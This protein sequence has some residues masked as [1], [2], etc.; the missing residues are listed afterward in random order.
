MN[1][2]TKVIYNF[3]YDE[4]GLTEIS[5]ELFFSTIMTEAFDQFHTIQFIEGG[6]LPSSGTIVQPLITDY[7][8]GTP[9]YQKLYPIRAG[10][11]QSN[12]TRSQIIMSPYPINPSAYQ[13]EYGEISFGWWPI[14]NTGI[15]EVQPKLTGQIKTVLF[16]QN[17]FSSCVLRLN[18]FGTNLVNCT[19]L[20]TE[21]KSV[22]NFGQMPITHVGVWGNSELSR[23]GD[24]I[25]L[26]VLNEEVG[27]ITLNSGTKSWSCQNIITGQT[28]NIFYV[29]KGTVYD[30][31]NSII[32]VQKIFKRGV[33][34]YQCQ[35]YS[36]VDVNWNLEQQFFLTTNIVFHDISV[37]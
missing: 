4:N 2:I 27:N 17:T 31:Q 18:A 1:A 9:G 21:I 20:E 14:P 3:A 15:C 16:G 11:V 19:Q 29:R 35:G 6:S 32:S 34:S 13:D 28:I 7:H 24:W 22:L 30:P 12:A 5:V 26:S 10:Y 36:C 8:S 33:I 37:S 23:L 25:K